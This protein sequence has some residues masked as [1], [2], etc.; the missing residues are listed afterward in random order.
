MFRLLRAYAERRGQIFMPAL[1]SVRVYAG[2][3]LLCIADMYVYVCTHMCV[4]VRVRHT[5]T[6]KKLRTR[7]RV[8]YVT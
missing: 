8:Y 3:C 1:K 7:A 2:H 5:S 4:C 6:K